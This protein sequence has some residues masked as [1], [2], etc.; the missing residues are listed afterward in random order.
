M[1]TSVL[2]DP[3]ALYYNKFINSNHQF[4]EP[5]H[6]IRNTVNS[7]STNQYE[8]LVPEARQPKVSSKHNNLPNKLCINYYYLL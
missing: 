8:F 7:T 4:T 3:Q 1:L 5:T 6:Y 2:F